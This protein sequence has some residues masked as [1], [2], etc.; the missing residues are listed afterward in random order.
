[1]CVTTH[2]LGSTRTLARVRNSLHAGARPQHGPTPATWLQAIAL[3]PIPGERPGELT[4]GTL[5]TH[6]VGE[7]RHL[8]RLG[9]WQ[10]PA[11][12]DGRRV[13]VDIRH[14]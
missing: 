1:M 9:D 12:S 5:G 8:F 2:S 11:A 6:G 7:G 3:I 10:L 4:A 13:P 14:K